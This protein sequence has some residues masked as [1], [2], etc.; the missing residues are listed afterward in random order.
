MSEVVESSVD[1]I[2]RMR[3]EWED[4]KRQAQK[5]YAEILCSGLGLSEDEAYGLLKTVVSYDEETAFDNLNEREVIDDD[6]LERKEIK[7]LTIKLL[8]GRAVL[9]A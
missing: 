2:K 5:P 4:K 3:K 7:T 1:K 6:K 8:P 9:I